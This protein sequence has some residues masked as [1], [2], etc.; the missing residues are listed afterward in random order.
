[1]SGWSRS[2]FIGGI[3]ACGGMRLLHAA[4]G[5]CLGDTPNLRFGGLSDLHVQCVGGASE[6][7]PSGLTTTS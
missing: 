6:A 3:G 5:S 1:M 2:G 4:P 7:I